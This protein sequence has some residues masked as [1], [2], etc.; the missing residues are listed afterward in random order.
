[1]I[2]TIILSVIIAVTMTLNALLLGLVAYLWRGRRRA[3]NAVQS[4]N[5][6]V[7]SLLIEKAAWIAR[8]QS[9]P[10]LLWR[11]KGDKVLH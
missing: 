4:L 6:E 11:D 7:Y 9:K 3:M 2:L 1:M 10:N 8:E 5:A